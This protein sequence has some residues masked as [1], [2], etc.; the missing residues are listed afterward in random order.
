MPSCPLSRPDNSQFLFHNIIW[1][2][3]LLRVIKWVSIYVPIAF[4]PYKLVP[5][6]IISSI[7]SS[8][9]ALI[10]LLSNSCTHPKKQTWLETFLLKNSLGVSVQF[11][12]NE[13]N[14]MQAMLIWTFYWR[15]FNREE[16]A[17]RGE[18]RYQDVCIHCQSEPNILIEIDEWC[19]WDGINPVFS[20]HL[21]N[22]SRTKSS[23]ESHLFIMHF[24]RTNGVLVRKDTDTDICT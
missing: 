10:V 17:S 21:Q 24:N 3:I 13:T 20:F 9:S 12:R 19:N 22:I 1:S 5:P 18:E 16:E 11:S 15:Q 8:L 2:R 7:S 4:R 6:Q 14:E 23:N